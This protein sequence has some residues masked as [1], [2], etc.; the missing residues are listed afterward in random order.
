M[1]SDRDSDSYANDDE[2]PQHEVPLPAYYIARYPVTVAQFLAFMQDSDGT[3]E[4]PESLRGPANHPVVL[5]TWH[6]AVAYC[7]WLTEKLAASNETPADLRRL[8]R[9][10]GV[11]QPWQ[12]TLPSEAEWEKAARGTDGRIYPWGDEAEA[13]RAN[14][15]ETNINRTTAVGCFPGGVSSFGVEE[16]SG[17]V[18]EWTRS[19]WGSDLGKPDFRYPYQPTDGRE[20]PAAANDVRRVLRGGSFT[21]PGG[22]SAPPTAT[23]TIPSTVT[24]TSGVGWW[25]PHSSSEL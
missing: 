18:W 10:D 14:Y 11:D 5:V 24:S 3:P 6:E 13:N 7:R 22:T 21:I 1:G 17:N 9:G 12:V 16:M 19:L 23:G 8:L 20:D 15:D 4:E 2:T 25:C